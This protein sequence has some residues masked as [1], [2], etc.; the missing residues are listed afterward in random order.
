MPG[1]LRDTLMDSCFV[2]GKSLCVA[3]LL[4]LLLPTFSI[5]N[6]D[7]AQASAN[8]L[9]YLLQLVC[10]RRAESSY[11]EGSAAYFNVIPHFHLLFWPIKP[12]LARSMRLFIEFKKVN[13]GQYPV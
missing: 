5:R 6:I 10:Q 8:S 4:Q 7:R 1:T 3:L 2:R 13:T 12:T 11:R 9:Q